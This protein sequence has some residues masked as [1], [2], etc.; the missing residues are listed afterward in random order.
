M[1]KK[2]WVLV[3]FLIMV[4]PGA[5]AAVKTFHVQENDLVTITPETLDPDHDQVIY[6][7]SPPLDKN[8]QWQTGYDDDGEYLLKIAAFDGINKTTKDVLLIVDNKNQPPYLTEKKV[9]VKELQSLDLKQLVADPDGD[10]L[11]YIF[12]KPFD[13][14]GFWKPGY[15]DQGTFIATFNARDGEFTVPMRLE[16]EVLNTNQPPKILSSFSDA[17]S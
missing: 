8:G 12:T 16:V 6:T 4:V 2:I 3:L 13:G 11:E 1:R 17:E 9:T 14:K 7:Y 5:L 10:P 15:D